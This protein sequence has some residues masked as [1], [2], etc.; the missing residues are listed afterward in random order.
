VI[1]KKGAWRQLLK[2]TILEILDMADGSSNSK[3]AMR[4]VKLSE[5]AAKNCKV[6]QVA[7]LARA[8]TKS[9]GAASAGDLA[10]EEANRFYQLTHA[11]V[12][13]V[14][15]GKQTNRNA[16]K[17]LNDG[18]LACARKIRSW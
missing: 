14:V 10:T 15:A 6:R 18:I 4:A 16:A 9:W 11:I 5:V 3:Q 2:P 8:F 13:A 17:A 7:I 12:F 1:D